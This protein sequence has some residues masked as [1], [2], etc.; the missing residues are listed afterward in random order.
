[1][2]WSIIDS[3]QL[4]RIIFEMKYELAKSV[5]VEPGMAVIDVG[6]GQGGFTVSA[7]RVVGAG[8]R[9]LSVDVSEE[10]MEEFVGNLERWNV[11]HI[12]TF[13]K[14]DVA[15]LKGAVDDACGDM[16]VSFRFLEEL[17]QASDMPRVIKEMARISKNGGKVCLVEISTAAK[18]KAE[19][20]YIKLH[21]E[22]GDCFF[23]PAEITRVMKEV[24]LQGVRMTKFETDVWFSPELAKRDLGFAQVWFDENVERTLGSSINSYGMK[25]PQLDVFSGMKPGGRQAR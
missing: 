7:A 14:A 12:V 13:V 9:V 1:M 4:E 16:V 19:E 5:G 8:G 20:T 10:Y 2:G 24:G 6:C 23:E 17:K 3:S 18:N 21:K 25:Y 11:A 15:D 22:S